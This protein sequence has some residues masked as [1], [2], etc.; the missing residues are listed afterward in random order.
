MQIIISGHGTHHTL[1]K[2]NQ[3]NEIGSNQFKGVSKDI[4]EI[5]FGFEMDYNQLGVATAAA[6]S[7]A[8]AKSAACLGCRIRRRRCDRM[9]PVCTGCLDLNVPPELC[10]YRSIGIMSKDS[11][12]TLSVIKTQNAELKQQLIHLQTALRK[13]KGTGL[14]DII[15]NDDYSSDEVERE[16]SEANKIQKN[17]SLSHSYKHLQL[18]PQRNPLL[19]T[20]RETKFSTTHL[21]SISL[22]AL[23]QSE[24]SIKLLLSQIHTVIRR[25]RL[26]YDAK[27]RKFGNFVK[28]DEGLNSIKFKIL[29]RMIGLSPE[30]DFEILNTIFAEIEKNFPDSASLE[31]LLNSYFKHNEDRYV[32]FVYVD[33]ETTRQSFNRFLDTSGK[34]PKINIKLPEEVDKLPG[35]L[36][37]LSAMVFSTFLKSVTIGSKHS[38]FNYLLYLEYAEAILSTKPFLEDKYSSKSLITPETLVALT[39]IVG[40][41]TYTPHGRVMDQ[42]ANGAESVVVVRRLVDIAKSLNLHKNIDYYY[43]DKNQSVR[44]S[45]KNLWFFLVHIEQIESFEHGLPSKIHPKTIRYYPDYSNSLTRVTLVINQILGVYFKI[46]TTADTYSFVDKVEN[47]CIRPLKSSLS[48]EFGSLQREIDLLQNFNFDDVS[49]IPEFRYLVQQ[50]VIRFIALGMLQAFHYLCFKRLEQSG[51]RSPRYERFK[52]LTWKYSMVVPILVA[53]VLTGFKRLTHHPNHPR[54]HVIASLLQLSFEMRMAERRMGIYA[55]AR[56]LDMLKVG[57]S[58]MIKK[59]LFQSKKNKNNEIHEILRERGEYQHCYTLSDFDDSQIDDNFTQLMDKFSRFQDVKYI[60]VVFSKKM[61]EILDLLA[62]GNY[63]FNYMKLNYGFF[64]MLK[65]SSLFLNLVFPYQELSDKA[66]IKEEVSTSEE[67]FDFNELFKTAIDTSSSKFDFE[68]FFTGSFGNVY[69]V[70]EIEDFFASNVNRY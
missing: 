54:F 60:I 69:Q 64:L 34:R 6:G 65:M 56:I 12:N 24:P 42:D 13:T 50:M 29:D 28:N 23:S 51:D 15:E 10:V 43:A 7:A 1:R 25:E 27:R 52:I 21:G 3:N 68:S 8:D 26:K 18:N 37:L 49:L 33:E 20:I 9:K 14:T 55:S 32:V 22:D 11:R 70:N 4:E 45:L 47:Q 38:D 44:K 40:F 16:L 59:L 46:E 63:N 48:K 19:C 41:E 58:T 31:F 62:N 67:E 36:L 53:E 17:S 30:N 2:K 35:L 39:H 61:L 57:N 5:V 66:I